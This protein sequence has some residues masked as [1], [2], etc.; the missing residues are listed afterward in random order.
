VNARW[1]LLFAA[2][3]A[4]RLCHSGI[5]WVEEAYPAA[6]AIQLLHG[7]ALYR[8]VFFDKPP[9][10]PLVYLL[11]GAHHGA[12][13]RVAGALY[14]TLCCWLAWRFARALWSER[15]GWIAAGLTAFYLTFGWPAAVMALA[16]DLLLLAPHIAAVYLAWRGRALA[17]GAM[18]GVAMLV[19]TK[20]LFVLAACAVWAAP[21]TWARIAAGFAGV[22][23]VQAAALAATGALSGYWQQVWAWG[24]RYA[25]ET[26]VADPVM[27]GL[28]RSAGWAGFHATAI[29]GACIYW[30]RGRDNGRLQFVLWAVIALAAVCGGWRF[31]PRYYFHLLPVAVLAGARGLALLP[32]RQALALAALL[33]IPL[34]RFGPRY[35]KLVL[36]GDAGWSDTAMNRESQA[37][38]ESLRGAAPDGTLLVWG[39]RPDL[40][41]YTR[42]KAGTPWLD[43]QPLTGVI[44]DRHLVESRPTFPEIAEQNRRALTGMHPT[45]VVDGLRRHN[46]A[47]DIGA[48]TDLQDWLRQYREVGMGVYVLKEQ[49]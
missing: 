18:A 27:E 1:A 24:A 5:L 9:L 44:A 47:L 40:W 16:P 32:R 37:I 43:S 36:E 41:V 26:F 19:H 20:G 46:P 30:L 49:Q 11:W 7:K 42:R 35:V 12:V 21:A 8:D 25:A 4:A 38:A 48:Y 34:A 31:F 2:V 3:L 6:A 23:A 15:E 29:A 14:V 39:Y 17:A 10:A 33:L 22:M 28:R 13:L 45:I